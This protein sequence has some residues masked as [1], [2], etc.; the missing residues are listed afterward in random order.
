MKVYIIGITGMLCSS[1]FLNF[2]S[3]NKFQVKGSARF[4]N[5]KSFEY[6]K[7]NIDLNTDVKNFVNLKQKILSFKPDYGINCVGWVKQKKEIT[8]LRT[9]QIQ[10]I[11]M[12]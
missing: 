11:Y 9:N 10:K 8:K 3:N 5:Y 7:K 6:Y 2:I 4:K 12:V 1:L